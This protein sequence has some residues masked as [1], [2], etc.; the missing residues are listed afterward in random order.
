MERR[1]QNDGKNDLV[2]LLVTPAKQA[3]Q[4]RVFD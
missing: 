3:Y 2:F 1:E 4:Q